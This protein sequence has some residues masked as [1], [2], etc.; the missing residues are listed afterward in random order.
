ME[1]KLAAILSAD[2]VGYSRLMGADEDATL[3]ALRSHRE[4]ID[5][6]IGAHR[7]RVFNSAGDSVVAEFPSAVEASLCAVQIQQDMAQRN[8]L[9]PLDK[10]LQFRIGIHIGDVVS[11]GGNL[12]GDGVN[13]ADR[14]QKLAAAGGICVS[15]NVYDQL[16]SKVSF[17]LESMGE[18]RVKNIASP[19]S[20]YR[21]LVGD[22]AKPRPITSRLYALARRSSRVA[23]IGAVLLAVISSLAFWQWQRSG[24]ARDGFPSVAVL[25]FQNFSGDP[26]LD[27]YGRVIAEDL[28]TAMS[29]FPDITVLSQNSSFGFDAT[30]VT[31]GQD[32]K[33]DY[34]VE[35][36]VQKKGSGLAI[37]AQ[38]TD[39][40]TDAH[41][42]AE[43]YDGREASDL[44]DGA[45]GRIANA[46]AS[47]GGAIRRYEYKRTEGKDKTDFSEYDYFLSGHEIFAR[48]ASIEEHDRAGA[49]WREGLEKFP[50]SGLLRVSLA[51]YHFFR[52]WNFN[53][54]KRAAD[55]RRA[56]ELAREAL[57][58]QNTSPR[59]QW[60]GRKLM[61]YI[62]WLEGNFER[63]VADAEAAVALAPYDADTLSF[64][65]RVQA[66]SGNTTRALEWVQESVRIEPTVQRT[67]RIL[68]WIYYLTG[69]YEK[70]LEAAKKHQELSRQFGDDASFYMVTSYV[71]LGRM[72][73]ARGALK[74]ALEAEPQWS[75]LNERNNHLE[76][77]YKNS[78]VFERQL[79]DLAA[80]GL[81]ELP[82][83][84]DG[85]LVDRLNS[86]EIKA[87]TFGHTL[88]A[89][90]MRSGSSFTDVIASN[91]TIQSSGDFGQDTAT[92]QYLGNSL[93]CY[94]WKDTGPNCAAV[95]RSR[96]ETS[97]AAGEFTLVDAWGEYRYSM[98]K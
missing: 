70:S 54:D 27:S 48:F 31:P 91:G 24:P 34:I 40:S 30:D 88:R 60:S 81:P 64:L 38:L 83:G 5:A 41:V 14:V 6:L 12:F 43:R 7:G 19:I 39:V 73:D 84:Y 92:I 15:R 86:E 25:A 52:P 51:W 44:Q 89:K 69:E 46:L 55:Y 72:E 17:K 78:A 93:I 74:Q 32:L 42:W 63:A 26:G 71:R 22:A 75:Q 85:E 35:G 57:A 98:E 58:E 20:V 65:S 61:A 45:I 50:T 37:N 18:H 56:G 1:R 94:R 79:E 9:V 2:V 68:A 95:F 80:A 97:K 90:D 21:V 77:P 33:V 59:V 82:F 3:E 62:H 53:T 16:T 67:T 49:I 23:A 96:N 87:M 13:I 36:S 11:E 10:Q 76:R 66:A 47:E 4:I 28:T 8:E 29:R